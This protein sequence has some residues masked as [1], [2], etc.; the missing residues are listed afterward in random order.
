MLPPMVVP[1][2]DAQQ[3]DVMRNIFL[4]RIKAGLQ[5]PQANVYGHIFILSHL[6]GLG[7]TSRIEKSWVA[8]V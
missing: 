5:V 6:E 7:E 2:D 8:G 4:Q 1:Q 3:V